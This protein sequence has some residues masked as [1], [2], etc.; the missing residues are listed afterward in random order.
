MNY[1]KARQRQSDKRWDYTCMND[2]RIWPIG[3]C[4][5]WREYT[6]EERKTY[7]MND[8]WYEEYESR[9]AKYHS[10]GHATPEEAC[11]CYKEYQLD[12]ALRF[13]TQPNRKE[14]CLVCGEWTQQMAMVGG[15]ETYVLCE[16]HAN[17]EEVEKLYVVGESAES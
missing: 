4:H 17:R 8:G 13:G 11:A 6:P 7:C 9:K 5:E 12:T 1:L 16:K 10:T 15:Y 14:Q 3:Y 2:R